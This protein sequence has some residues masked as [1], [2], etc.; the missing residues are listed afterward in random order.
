MHAYKKFQGV[1]YGEFTVCLARDMDFH[2]IE[3]KTI[4]GFDSAW[5]NITRPCDNILECNG[6]YFSVLMDKS[7]LKCSGK[8]CAYKIIVIETTKKKINNNKTYFLYTYR[9]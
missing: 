4:D 7:E 5:F 9:K 1:S 3:C 8:I 2:P 6:I